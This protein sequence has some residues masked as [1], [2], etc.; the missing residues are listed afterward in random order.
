MDVAQDILDLFTQPIPGDAPCGVS[1]KYEESFLALEA[2][3]AKQESLIAATVDWRQ[4]DQ[5]AR[6]ILANESKDLL[7]ACYLAAALQSN[8]GYAGTL[9]GLALVQGLCEQWW[10]DCFPPLKRLRGRTAA[11]NWLVEKIA[12][13]LESS[14]PQGEALALVPELYERTHALDLWLAEK[15]D[16]KAPDMTA[17][18]RPLRQLKKTVEAE[19]A[20]QAKPPPAPAPQ[21]EVA[22]EPTAE[23]A[24][25][26]PEPAPPAQPESPSAAPSAPAPPAKAAAA[27]GNST[28]PKADINADVASDADANKALRQIQDAMRKLSAFYAE[29]AP[30]QP[31]RFR[32]SRYALW[33]N[34][35][36][37]PPNK[38]GKT[39]VPPPAKD[40]GARL[41]QALDQSDFAGAIE[42]VEK[43]L[44]KLPYWFEGQ[45][46]LVQALENMGG[47]HQAALQVVMAELKSLLE[48]LPGLLELSY[49]DGT[50]FADDA[51]R[52]WLSQ[53]VLASN[54]A[55]AQAGSEPDGLAEVNAEA[56]K[57]AASGKVAEGIEALQQFSRHSGSRRQEYRARLALAE[58]L[59][60]SGQPASAL[61]ILVRLSNYIEQHD[62]AE[63]EPDFARQC[64]QRLHQACERG[65]DENHPDYDQLKKKQASAY[66]ELC[67][68]D[69]GSAL[70]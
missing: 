33:L 55:S 47:S 17:I 41:Q 46:L 70:G 69:A 30:A 31:R 59:L 66:S 13:Q 44:L 18:V 25:E 8:Q 49:S 56:I 39:Q 65:L 45:R 58:V 43:Q 51:T 3:L 40:L 2:E 7:V 14:P 15:M 64:Y 37:L 6:A 5:L 63:W 54:E 32:L 57:L 52:F 38:D 9:T 22:A 21:P 24:T 53:T 34:I 27:S 48:R 29:S 60:D 50:P 4:V 35:D 1:V 68:Y 26:Q 23:S 19:Q 10:D 61:P 67:W 36:A 12:W 20:A 62:L 28:V 11:V 42:Q 16:D